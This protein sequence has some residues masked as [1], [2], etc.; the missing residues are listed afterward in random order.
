M[1]ITHRHVIFMFFEAVYSL[2]PSSTQIKS[3]VPALVT[4]N[5]KTINGLM[6]QMVLNLR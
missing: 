6:P 4:L 1:I 3:N 2:P 5:G